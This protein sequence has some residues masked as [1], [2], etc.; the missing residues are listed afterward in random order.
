MEGN[1]IIVKDGEIVVFEDS[2]STKKGLGID[3]P[4]VGQCFHSEEAALVFYKSYA[5][6]KG[7]LVRKGQFDNDQGERIRRDFVCHREGSSETKAKDE[8]ARREMKSLIF[9]LIREGNSTADYNGTHN[10]LELSKETLYTICHRCVTSI[11]LCLSEAKSWD[12]NRG[13]LSEITREADNLEWVV[14][15]LIEKRICED[16]VKL[17][18]D[19]T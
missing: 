15:I 16:F 10:K 5:T 17:W 7:F 18:S 8:K 11:I 4:F 6:I 9:R 12:E 14:D 1:S 2:R 3:E 19:Q 13:M